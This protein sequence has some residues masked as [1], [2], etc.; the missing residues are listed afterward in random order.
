MPKEVIKAIKDRVSIR[1]YLA[2]DIADDKIKK[3]I[4][5][6][7]LA[8]S[9]GN[10]QPWQFHV[11]KDKDKIKQLAQTTTDQDWIT[12]SPVVIVISALTDISGEKYGERGSNLYAIQDTAAAIENLLLAAEAY[13]LGSCWV[14]DFSEQEA[15]KILN[16]SENSWPVALVT[17]GYPASRAEETRPQRSID[18]VLTIIN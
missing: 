2:K 12:S 13:D 7:H 6:A 18:D 16:I 3:I 4:E 15:K 17:L 11:V 9:A 10:L 5:A 8:P 14:G 1:D